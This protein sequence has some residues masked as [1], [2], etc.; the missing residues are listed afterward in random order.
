[1]ALVTQLCKYCMVLLKICDFKNLTYTLPITK[2]KNDV[3]GPLEDNFQ[4]LNPDLYYL[5]HFIETPK[6]WSQ[7]TKCFKGGNKQVDGNRMRVGESFLHVCVP[8]WVSQQ[9]NE[10]EQVWEGERLLRT[11]RPAFHR[12]DITAY[13]TLLP[14]VCMRS[15]CFSHTHN[16]VI[17]TSR[18]AL[19]AWKALYW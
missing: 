3:H 7:K 8:M 2:V 14:R 15:A 18:E 9:D 16:S 17:R 5:K 12:G 4:P 13:Y 11:L 6:L 10:S 19:Q 1:M